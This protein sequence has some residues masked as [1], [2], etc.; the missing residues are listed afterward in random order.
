MAAGVILPPLFFERR[1]LESNFAP[2]MAFSGTTGNATASAAEFDGRRQSAPAA[3]DG[4]P[5]KDI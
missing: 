3:R 1:R 4:S 2:R 5:L